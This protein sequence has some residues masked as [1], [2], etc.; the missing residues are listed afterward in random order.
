MFDTILLLS[1]ADTIFL[2]SPIFGFVM[3]ILAIIILVNMVNRNNNQT[4]RKILDDMLKNKD[5][6]SDVYI[7]YLNEDN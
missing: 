6:S 3:F 2:I 7:K 1:N 4:K 5:I